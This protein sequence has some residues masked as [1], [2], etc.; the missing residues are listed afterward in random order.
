VDDDEW[1]RLAFAFDLSPR[2]LDVLRNVAWGGTEK[3]GKVNER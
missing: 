2:E 1:N 3:E